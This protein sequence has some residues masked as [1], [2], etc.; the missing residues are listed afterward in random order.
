LNVKR[1]IQR[2]ATEAVARLFDEIHGRLE[3][4]EAR[5]L[6]FTDLE[7][8]VG[9]ELERLKGL[10]DEIDHRIERGNKIWRQIRARERRAEGLEELEESDQLS[11]GDE[12]GGGVEGLSPV[13]EGL[14]DYRPTLRPHQEVGKALA[15][16]YLEGKTL[17]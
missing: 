3:D 5:I 9:R 17:G 8:T 10:T 11:F 15:R 12:E 4:F 2:L 14:D 13:S 16:Q 6:E 7:R 1:W